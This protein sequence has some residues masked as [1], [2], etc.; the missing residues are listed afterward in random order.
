MMAPF[1][2]AAVIQA[3]DLGES[4]LEEYTKAFKCA[5]QRFQEQIKS[6]ERLEEPF[7]TGIYMTVDEFRRWQTP[8][9]PTHE[10]VVWL[11]QGE[12]LILGS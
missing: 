1:Q 10:N 5:Q 7:H 3:E 9:S 11:H 4:R 12:V 2:C 8:I 6:E